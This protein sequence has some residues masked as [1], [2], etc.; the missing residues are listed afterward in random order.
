MQRFK[1]RILLLLAVW[2]LLPHEI[3]I[4]IRGESVTLPVI[5][6]YALKRPNL[7]FF[8]VSVF[9]SCANYAFFEGGVATSSFFSSVIF[10]PE[11]ILD[12]S[13]LL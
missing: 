13:L 9:L 2:R 10:P 8:D 11:A 1:S 3:R 4:T 6:R 7:I 12:T 5:R